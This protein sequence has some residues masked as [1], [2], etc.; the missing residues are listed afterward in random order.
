MALGAACVVGCESGQDSL[1]D[2][3][4]V[5][6]MRLYE[7]PYE[8]VDWSQ[9]LRLT[10]Q[11]HD[12]IGMR[13]DGILAYDNA[14]YDVVSLMDYSGNVDLPYARRQRMWPLDQWVSTALRSNLKNIKLFIPN[15]EEVGTERKTPGDPSK[16][17]TSPF[18]TTY[19]EGAAKTPA[20]APE[21]PLL[22]NQYRSL[23]QMF[24]LINSL[25]GFPCIAHPYDYRYT[26]LDLGTSYCVEIYSAHA[27]VNRE[28]GMEFYTQI[29][30][31]IATVQTWDE[32]L[33]RSQ[34]IFGIGV[35]D[36]YGPQATRAPISEK[37]RDSGKILVLAKEVSLAAYERA[38]RRGSYFAVRDFGAVK[39]RY[40]KV[41]SITTTDDSIYLETVDRVVWIANGAVVGES[42]LLSVRDLPYG[43]RY[44]R[45]E[46]TN[47]DGSVVYTQAFSIRPSGDVDGDYD[48]DAED[49][50]LC[51]AAVS[52]AHRRACAATKASP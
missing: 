51:A 46:V 25:G 42:P 22:A 1:G 49:V 26:N 38:F 5:P 39:N 32:V 7:S 3:A 20:D 45:A 27:E 2:S 18:L 21:L 33:M 30:R 34:R 14:G 11:H 47:N 6:T 9:D 28:R 29:D 35:N 40:P 4:N 44:A 24:S 36:H 41:H 37:V 15:G 43:T 13:V 52:P 23:E 8:E 19:I 16:H 31:N 50:A 17:A 12:H 48:V 10:A